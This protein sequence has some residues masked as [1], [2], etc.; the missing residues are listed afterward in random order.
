L[1]ALKRQTWNNKLDS[2]D[3]SQ[4]RP[5]FWLRHRLALT[6]EKK[7]LVYEP[8]GSPFGA[9]ADIR[10]MYFNPAYKYH[11]N[12]CFHVRQCIEGTKDGVDPINKRNFQSGEPVYILRE[13]IGFVRH[14][15][16]VECVPVDSM[17]QY[18]HDLGMKQ[19]FFQGF[20]D[21]LKRVPMDQ[22]GQSKHLL[23]LEDYMIFFIFDDAALATGIC[24]PATEEYPR[25]Q[26]ASSSADLSLPEAPSETHVE[27]AS[28]GNLSMEKVFYLIFMLA[29]VLVCNSLSNSKDLRRLE[30][31]FDDALIHSF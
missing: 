18:I 28:Y 8:P 23:T 16:P 2:E 29:F 24:P 27:V 3:E 15:R 7:L 11:T 25:I 22:D 4:L 31:H 17:R 10:K 21:P 30:T 1:E 20:P 13:N 12:G 19:I 9:V 26:Q 14:K 6:R 5:F